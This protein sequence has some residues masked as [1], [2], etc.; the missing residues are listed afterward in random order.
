MRRSAEHIDAGRDYT[1]QRRA[2]GQ[3]GEPLREQFRQRHRDRIESG[4]NRDHDDQQRHNHSPH[5]LSGNTRLRRGLP[6]AGAVFVNHCAHEGQTDHDSD[7]AWNDESAAPAEILAD[8]AGD[9]R[10]RRHAEIAPDA[11][12]PH[13]TAQPVRVRHD[14]SRADG[15]VDRREQTDRQQRRAELQRRLHQPHRDHRRPDAGEEDCHH[16]AAA[17]AVAKPAGQ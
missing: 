2:L 9:H 5:V 13:F 3:L 16:V 12:Q 15:M 17:P 14:H 8:K 10:R 11:V 6:L 7:D 4:G 1:Q